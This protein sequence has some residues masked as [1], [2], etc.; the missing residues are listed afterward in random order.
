MNSFVFIY[1]TVVNVIPC[2]CH[3]VSE[4]SNPSTWTS[5]TYLLRHSKESTLDLSQ[6]AE[7][8]SK[9]SKTAYFLQFTSYVVANDSP[10]YELRGIHDSLRLLLPPLDKSLESGT[11]HDLV[12]AIT[13]GLSSCLGTSLGNSDLAGHPCL[14]F[15]L[16]SF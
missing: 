8:R 2:P 13:L 7:K 3:V 5:K 4:S 11:R 14:L 12:L 9:E 10:K 6:K 1:C 15:T 16:L